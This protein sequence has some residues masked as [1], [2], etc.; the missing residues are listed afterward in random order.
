MLLPRY[1][2]PEPTPAIFDDHNDR[3]HEGAGRLDA[4][5]VDPDAG[6]RQRL[7]TIDDPLVRADLASMLDEAPFAFLSFAAKTIALHGTA[8]PALVRDLVRAGYWEGVAL[9]TSLWWLCGLRP[10]EV[11][12]DTGL[13][14]WLRAL[15]AHRASAARRRREGLD[16]E[17]HSYLVEVELVGGWTGTLHVQLDRYFCSAVVHGFAADQSLAETLA[18]FRAAKRWRRENG[19]EVPDT[20]P[21]GAIGVERALDTL[22]GPLRDAE[23]GNVPINLQSPW[24]GIRTLLVFFVVDRFGADEDDDES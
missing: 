15:G 13:P 19:L 6:A 14:S 18:L 5:L 9:A 17:I 3:A 11:L 23:R 12:L 16:R 10:P 21:F 4:R 22:A 8:T 24:P 20:G 1:A 2:L 7:Q